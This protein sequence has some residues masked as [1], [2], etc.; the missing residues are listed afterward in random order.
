MGLEKEVTNVIFKKKMFSFIVWWRTQQLWGSCNC[1]SCVQI[2]V[3]QPS[4]NCCWIHPRGIYLDFTL[5]MNRKCTHL[6]CN[7]ICIDLEFLSL[8]YLV[9]HFRAPRRSSEVKSRTTFCF[10]SRRVTKTLTPNWVTSKKQP[11]TLRER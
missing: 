9:N 6:L 3:L 2:C 10:S 8:M 4:A 1:W 7:E 11:K 5:T